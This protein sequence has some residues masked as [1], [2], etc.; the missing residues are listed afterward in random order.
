MCIRD[1]VWAVS[2]NFWLFLAAAILNCFEQINQT[3]WYCLC[4][5]YTSHAKVYEEL[6]QSE[7]VAVCA[8]DSARAEA[9]SLIHI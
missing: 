2:N 8:A 3:A 4:L 9:L 5:L 1:R 6:P 7:F